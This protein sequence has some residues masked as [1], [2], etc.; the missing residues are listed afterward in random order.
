MLVTTVRWPRISQKVR[1]L[2]LEYH[3]FDYEDRWY[4]WWSSVDTPIS[5]CENMVITAWEIHYK[6]Y[7]LL[8]HPLRVGLVGIKR[9]VTLRAVILRP[10][11]AKL[12]KLDIQRRTVRCIKVVNIYE[13]IDHTKNT[14]I[15]YCFK[16][17]TRVIF[18]VESFV[19][20]LC[21]LW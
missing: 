3:V 13:T 15:L 10:Y 2:S 7:L 11:K 8:Q 18:T 1:S 12:S 14:C 4:A 21:S 19:A 6:D 5:T 20:R 9:N 16:W 17:T